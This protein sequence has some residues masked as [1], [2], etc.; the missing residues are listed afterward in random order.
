MAFGDKV[1]VF[2]LAL[3]CVFNLPSALSSRKL[4]QRLDII[5]ARQMLETKIRKSETE[6]MFEKIENIE[7]RI[8]NLTEGLE[9][10]C[11]HE[12]CLEFKRKNVETDIKSVKSLSDDVK[13]LKRYFARLLKAFRVEKQLNIKARQKFDEI[14]DNKYSGEE[15]KQEIIDQI[16]LMLREEMEKIGQQIYTNISERISEKEGTTIAAVFDKE[17]TDEISEDYSDTEVEKTTIRF[18]SCLELL[19]K[20]GKI[21]SGIYTINP[22]GLKPAIRVYCDQETEGGG[23]TVF[24][25]RIDGSVEFYRSW[26]DYKVGFGDLDGEFWLGNDFLSVLTSSGN[27][28]LRIDLTDWKNERCHA[29]YSGFRIGPE[30]TNYILSL[31]KFTGGSCGDSLYYHNGMQFSTRD[32]DNDK[33]DTYC[34]QSYMG[35]WWYNACLYSGLNGKYGETN[36]KKGSGI[37]WYHWKKTYDDYAKFSE[38]KFK[39]H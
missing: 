6:E 7:E 2:S 39:E 35:A 14:N 32:R 23:W 1:F 15:I 10:A 16:K 26:A 22:N 8:A 18:K 27:H 24:Q 38:M 30:T 37:Y 28:D 21:E 13:A 3:L 5:E 19:Q 12:E 20:G 36:E 33:K 34:A 17:I 4:N 25:R 31:S 11:K 9:I 29:L